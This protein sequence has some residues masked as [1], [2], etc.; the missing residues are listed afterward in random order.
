VVL[1]KIQTVK[2]KN[3]DFVWGIIERKNSSFSKISGKKVAGI[4]C[5]GLS[6]AGSFNKRTKFSLQTGSHS[7]FFEFEILPVEIAFN[8]IFKSV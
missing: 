3:I 7:C 5:S 4:H 8:F 2:V 1:V 6:E